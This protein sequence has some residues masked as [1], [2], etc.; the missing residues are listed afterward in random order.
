MDLEQRLYYYGLGAKIPYSALNSIANAFDEARYSTDLGLRRK[1]AQEML[2][3]SPWAG[4]IP[5]DL[6][7]A[8]VGVDTLPGT[9]EAIEAARAI[10]EDRRQTGW[11]ARPHNPFYQCERDTDYVEYPALMKFALSDAVL[12]IVSDY[13]GLVPQM[14]SLAIWVTPPHD[15][16][17]SSQLFHLDKPEAR[18]VGL[19]LNV[20]STEAENGPLT[21]LPVN[22]SNK[23]RK[24]TDYE[25][26]YFRKDGRLADGAVFAHC[27]AGDQIELGGA[28][29]TG[30]FADTSNCFHF[31]SRCRSGE[32]RMLVIKFMLPHKAR[33]PRTPFFDLVPPPSDQARRLVLSGARF[34]NGG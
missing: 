32:R 11:K 3:D 18:I 6:G 12:H 28:A 21:L 9:R 25:W 20:D 24:K 23:V 31:G 29:G 4:F 19:F 26:V 27:S 30:G 15:H 10:I 34:K 5:K 7:Y 2:V 1:L 22:V 8:V 33:D 17:F 16:Q 14:K 13:Y